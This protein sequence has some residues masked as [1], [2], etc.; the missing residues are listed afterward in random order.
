MISSNLRGR[1]KAQGSA[2]IYLQLQYR[3][4]YD[5][6]GVVDFLSHHA[7]AGV[8]EINDSR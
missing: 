6:N 4:P 7:I 5:W 1:R 2:D 8:E 3:P